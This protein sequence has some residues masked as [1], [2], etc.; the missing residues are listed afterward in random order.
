[1]NTR[2]V[3]AKINDVICDKF[4][5]DILEKGLADKHFFSRDVN[6]YARNLVYILFETEQLFG[7]KLNEGDVLSDQFYTL[8]GLSELICSKTS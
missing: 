2:N 4:D 8:N 1:M 6:L 3:A 7:V 5:I